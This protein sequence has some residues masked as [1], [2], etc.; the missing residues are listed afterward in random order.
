MVTQKVKKGAFMR[1]L[2]V[3]DDYISRTQ[4]KA[5]LSGYGDCDAVPEG[6]LAL[7]MI[8]CSYNENVPYDLI[9]MD[10]DMPGMI[11]QEVVREIR[12]LEANQKVDF[13][14]EVKILMITVKDDPKSIMTSFK[15]G[16]E[17]VLKKP[18]TPDQIKE[19]LTNLGFL[20]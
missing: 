15:E 4:L 3:D 10:I 17:W 11:G 12:N 16:C 14:E 19:T 1:I 18:V 7:E 13:S 8:E 2:I 9:T 6:R 5:L 20:K